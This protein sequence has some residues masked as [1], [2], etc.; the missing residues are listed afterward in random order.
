MGETPFF[1]SLVTMAFEN[2]GKF[3]NPWDVETSMVLLV[4]TSII[5]NVVQLLFKVKQLF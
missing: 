1:P 2:F 4:G 5:L 3:E